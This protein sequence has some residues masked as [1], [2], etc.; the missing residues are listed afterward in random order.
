MTEVAGKP[1]L[2]EYRT[3]QQQAQ[4]KVDERE[5]TIKPQP[6]GQ[7]TFLSSPAFEVLFGGSAGGGKSWALMVDALGLQYEP[8]IGKCAYELPEYRAYIF[9]RTKNRFGNLIDKAKKLYYSLGARFIL[10]R[11][12][13]PGSFFEF[14]SG[15]K[16]YFC[17]MERVADKDKY[18][19]YEMH[20]VGFD[21][22]GEFEYE[23]YIYIFSRVRKSG[24]P[25]LTTRIRG[26]C[27]P[28]GVGLRWLKERF[29]KGCEK[30]KIYGYLPPI[31]DE[32]AD[33]DF[34]GNAVPIGT[35]QSLT[36]QF[37][38]GYLHENKI[39]VDEDPGYESRIR[40]M[41]SRYV[42]ALLHGDW[43]AFGGNMFNKLSREIHYIKPIDIPDD[44]AITISM[45]YGN[46]STAHILRKNPLNN[47]VY[48]THEWTEYNASTSAKIVSFYRFLESNGLLNL[49]RRL[50]VKADTN[51]FATYN[52]LE[53]KI[54]PADKFNAFFK[55][56]NVTF[57]PVSKK[58][59]DK[60]NFRIFCVD[61][62]YDAIDW[63]QNEQGKFLRRPRLYFFIGKCEKL[64]E[65]LFELQSDP[66]NPQ[67]VADTDN[68]H[69]FDS[70]KYGLISIR[71]IDIDIKTI[72]AKL[73]KKFT[74]GNSSSPTV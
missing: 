2:E 35:P 52:E 20:Y 8:I 57:V 68:D 13:E 11:T 25:G 1:V 17:E 64:F 51:M 28:L 32:N 21:E 58:S 18:Q 37:I 10:S 27:N 60:R 39:L 42:R 71:R 14:P 16:I 15:A 62:V 12:G 26:T 46:V 5:Y 49:N 70:L 30:Y 36:R 63:I 38:P 73:K 56:Y 19:G 59:P 53:E 43:D 41:G 22:L 66:N 3:A 44:W 55:K 9:R 24:L 45:D 54:S 29:I 72:Q 34:K 31:E 47:W 6:G 50:V 48:V 74:Y 61:E 4:D 23:Q 40:A 33:R 65:S 67:D 69:W 7:V